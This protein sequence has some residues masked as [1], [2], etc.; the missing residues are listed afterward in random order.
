MKQV[1]QEQVCG[2]IFQ[3]VPPGKAVTTRI[4]RIPKESV[5]TNF[6]DI[7]SSQWISQLERIPS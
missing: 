2:N 1:I 6:V 7:L 3:D 5:E 4:F